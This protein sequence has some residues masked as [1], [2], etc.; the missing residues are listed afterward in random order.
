MKKIL[1]RKGRGKA[2]RASSNGEKRKAL[3]AYRLIH[4]KGNYSLLLSITSTSG[5]GHFIPRFLIYEI[6]RNSGLAIHIRV[7]DLGD[8]ATFGNTGL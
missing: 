8:D 4:P 1:V 2:S 6:R 3:P 5:Q 7:V